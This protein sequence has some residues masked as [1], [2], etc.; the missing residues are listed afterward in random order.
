MLSRIGLTL[1]AVLVAG[2]ATLFAPTLAFAQTAQDLVGTWQ[3]VSVVNTA[4]DGTK[5][6]VFGPDLK[7]TA[8][9]AADGRFAYIVMRANL[10]NFASGNRL[11][12]TPEENK[13]IVQGSMAYFG[14]YAVADKAMTWHIE[15]SAWPAWTGM[16]QKQSIIAFSKNE[17]TIQHGAAIMGSNVVVLKRAN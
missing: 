13:A 4:E 11:Q 3:I 5:S 9:F 16:D 2:S 1:C 6:N 15:G 14:T 17:M 7:G 8:I 10:P 12:G